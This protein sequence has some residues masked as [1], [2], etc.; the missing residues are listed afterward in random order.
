[1]KKIMAVALAAFALSASAAW[2]RVG[3]VQLADVNALT[4]GVSK[5]GE[6]TGNQ[7][8]GMMVT[9]ALM[10]MPDVQL[11]GPGRDGAATLYVM[12]VDDAAKDDADFDSL[13]EFAILH[14][15]TQTKAE[16]IAAHDGCVEKDG[17]IRVAM[18]DDDDDDDDDDDVADAD[19]F[20]F[21]VFSPDGKWAAMSDKAAQAKAALQSVA[22]AERPMKNDLLRVFVD[23]SG[24]KELQKFFEKTA[25]KAAKEAKGECDLKQ[26]LDAVKQVSSLAA[27]LGVDDIGIALHGAVVPTKGSNLSQCGMTPLEANPLAFA[28]KDALVAV[29]EAAG[30]GA[31]TVKWSEIVKVLSKHGIKVQDFIAV[32]E[33]PGQT[34]FVLDTA[35]LIKFFKEESE[36][37]AKKID[38]KALK[39]DVSTLDKDKTIFSPKSEANK[40]TLSVKGFTPAVSPAER[41]AKVLPEAAKKQPFSVSVVS[42]YAVVRAILPEVSSLVEKDEKAMFDT[43]MAAMPPCG[44]GGMA[45]ATW[46]EKD[47]LF[48]L[49]K[50]S[51]DEVKG[52]SSMFSAFAAMQMQKAMKQAQ[53]NAKRQ[54]KTPAAA[55]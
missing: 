7:M 40:A 35:A 55:K 28:A 43:V 13:C 16:F 52:I 9:P 33:K 48:A 34:S 30:S 25:N 3:S 51:A 44:D 2:Q 47:K 8:L 11:F 6:M 50:V 42:Y 46:R 14:P 1:M 20:K 12:F 21:V 31:Q 5:V 54:T 36:K 45:C 15:V 49:V 24:M 37:L 53:E 17:V 29:A 41:L 27:G 4:K 10:G 18:E 22:Q 23:P 26:A 39:A 19:E 32:D 38:P